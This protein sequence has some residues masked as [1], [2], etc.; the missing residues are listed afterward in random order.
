MYA[1]DDV[2]T[3]HGFHVTLQGADRDAENRM[4]LA[5]LPCFIELQIHLGFVLA[6]PPHHAWHIEVI[7]LYCLDD[8]GLF[9]KLTNDG[10]FH[11][12]SSFGNSSKLFSQ[13]WVSK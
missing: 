4:G 9:P 5:E 2:V 1:F 6:N 12:F 13:S 8:N 10:L 7:E 3:R 11:F